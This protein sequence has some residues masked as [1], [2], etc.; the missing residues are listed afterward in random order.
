[1][2]Y[3]LMK[4]ADM[5]QEIVRTPDSVITDNEEGEEDD[6]YPEVVYNMISD[7]YENVLIDLDLGSSLEGI[8]ISDSVSGD[9]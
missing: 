5:E 2:A 7:I 1:M 9:D 8:E 4:Y 3:R 6:N